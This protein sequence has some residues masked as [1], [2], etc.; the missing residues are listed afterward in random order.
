[1]D[2]LFVV[3][4]GVD[5]CG[6]GAQS[7][8]L[9]QRLASLGLSVKAYWTPDRRTAAGELAGHLL[10]GQVELAGNESTRRAEALALQCLLTCCR[11]EVAARVRAD[12]VADT[13]VVCARWWPSAVVYAGED[14]L[15]A[16]VIRAH[17]SFLPEPDLYVLLDVVPVTIAGR[18]DPG[19]RYEAKVEVQERLADGYRRL[20]ADRAAVLPGKWVVVNAGREPAAVADQVW[21]KVWPL[22]SELAES[23]QLRFELPRSG[24]RP[25]RRGVTGG[26]SG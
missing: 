22:R 7:E 2:P 1:M 21:S 5:R 6:K 17:S 24:C 20:W 18:F 12:L 8:L 10:R 19:E 3:F 14:G 15:D 25:P 9:R 13:S 11:Y 4:E 16:E 26:E 23:R